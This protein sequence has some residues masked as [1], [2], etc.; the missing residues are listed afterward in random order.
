MARAAAL[1]AFL[2]AVG[3]TTA[4][5]PVFA[6]DCGQL[7]QRA[8][9]YSYAAPVYYK[10]AYVQ[11]YYVAPVVQ[12]RAGQDIEAEA[13]AEKISR[14]VAEKL[15]ALNLQQRQ[16]Q[17]VVLS[18][19]CAGCHNAADAKG[20]LVLDGSASVDDYYFRRIVEIVGGG[21]D[22]PPPMQR[23]IASL[24]P[25]EKGAILDEI[26]SLKPVGSSLQQ[27]GKYPP[28]QAPQPSYATP[29]GRPLGAG[30]IEESKPG[31]PESYGAPP[32]PQPEPAPLPPD[33]GGLR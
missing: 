10:Q 17:T 3:F 2:A 12:Y 14:R 30:D 31:P 7:F 23:V 28:Q 26:I 6:A 15:T 11:P 32:P 27:V 21:V 19:K 13:L 9:T 29:S 5:A 18:N 24:Q 8:Y 20:G 1:A 4:V 25:A 16:T 22:V 33:D